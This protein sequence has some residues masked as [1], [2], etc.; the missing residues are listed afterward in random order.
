MTLA[1]RWLDA[2][3]NTVATN[4]MP[5]VSVPAGQWTTLDFTDTA[6]AGAV[7]ASPRVWM[8]GIPSTSDVL[9][10]DEARLA[11]SSGDGGTV[12]GALELAAEASA[13][14]GVER[15]EFTVDGVRV[16]EATVEPYQVEVDTL[17]P[18]APIYDGPREFAAVAHDTFGQQTVSE[19]VTVVVDNTGG[20]MFQASIDAPDPP[21]AVVFDPGADQQH[22]YGVDVTVTNDSQQAWPAGEVSVVARWLSTDPDQQVVI[23]AAAEPLADQVPA[24][25]SETVRL[26][27]EP[28]PLPDGVARDRYT[29]EFDL[30]ADDPDAGGGSFAR[31]GNE[32]HHNPVIVQKALAAELGLE[33]YYQFDGETLGGGMTH[34]LNVANGNSLWRYSPFASPGRGLSTVVDLTYNS[35]EQR[36]NS[37]A[38]NNVSLSISGLTRLGAPIDIHPNK[39]DEI[40]GRADRFVEFVDGTGT[41]HRFVGHQNDDG[42]LWWEPPPG[43]HLYLRSLGGDD[44][45]RR[46]ALTRPDRVTFFYD[47]DGYPTSI[48]DGNGNRISFVLEDVPPGEDPGG[49]KRRITRVVDAAGHGLDPAPDRGYDIAYWSRADARKPQIRGKVR[50]I[51]DHEGRSL[52]FD[53]YEDGNLLRLTQAGGRTATGEALA[54]RSWVFTYTTA[55]GD[56]PAIGDPADRVDPD[57]RTPNQSTLLYSVADPRGAETVFD[58]Y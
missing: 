36:S 2:D 50:E 21:P 51:T 18:A 55:N 48:Q 53:Y 56:G 20:S 57:P 22:R 1:I 47:A 19:P 28:P 14:A 5:S 39:A 7:K 52:H 38:G 27:V 6:P 45:E 8:P 49:S 46:W 35:G 25:A 24:G 11:T 31:R 44:P 17:D 9:Y 13:E 40:A 32:P 4:S 12:G 23:E 15:V 3:D 33:R 26:L 16:G 41:T 29:L 30:V 37:P 42:T 43:V 34:L 58:Y 54:D 10:I